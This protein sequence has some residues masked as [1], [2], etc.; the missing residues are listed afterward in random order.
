MANEG[1]HDYVSPIPVL[2]SSDGTYLLKGIPVHPVYVFYVVPV[3]DILGRLPLVPAFDGKIPRFVEGK[4]LNQK[5][6]FSHGTLSRSSVFFI[7]SW[8]MRWPLDY[9][10]N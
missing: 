1:E 4:E 2:M 3:S 9:P 10:I 8:A 5:D 7:N 6:H